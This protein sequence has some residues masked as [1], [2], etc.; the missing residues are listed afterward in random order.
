MDTSLNVGKP[1]LS[2]QLDRMKAADLGVQISDAADAL[3]LLVGGDQ[4][5]TYNEGGE[6]Y[7]VHVRAVEGN[8]RTASAIEQ[9]TVPS[10]RNGSVPLQ[11]IARL[12]PGTAPSEIN[13]LNRQRQVTI[14]AGLLQGVSQTPAMDMMTRTADVAE[15]GARLQH[16][17]RGPLAR[18][19]ARGAELPAS[20]S[21]CR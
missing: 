20:P 8:R 13:R 3:R 19:R 11:N 18:A 2:V 16:A 14:F 10:S 4:V 1:E 9:L 21:R 12:T 5:T 6:Q 15:H 7:E 17:I